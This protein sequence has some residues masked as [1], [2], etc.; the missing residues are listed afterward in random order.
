VSGAHR[1]ASHRTRLLCPPTTRCS[2]RT[3]VV[4]SFEW[5]WEDRSN[6]QPGSEGNTIQACISPLHGWSKL[7]CWLCLPLTD[8]MI[9]SER[10]CIDGSHSVQASQMCVI[11]L[12]RFASGLCSQ[13][14]CRCP[15]PS[16]PAQSDD[17]VDGA[18]L[19]I[20][21]WTTQ[22]KKDLRSQCNLKGQ[23]I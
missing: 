15:P 12:N 23:S 13:I 11:M 14:D 20:Q 6:H 22:R 2:G 4:F 17:P 5:V 1:I 21:G 19:C 8:W 16:G 3:C 10:N 9:S 18:P 7:Q